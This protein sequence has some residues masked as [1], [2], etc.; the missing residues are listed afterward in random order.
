MLTSLFLAA[1]LWP[2]QVNS[3]CPPSE[4]TI[5]VGVAKDASNSFLYC[6]MLSQPE[7]HIIHIDYVRKGA[8]FA[9]KELIYSSPNS[10]APSVDQKDFRNGEIRKAQ[11]TPTLIDLE[12][13]P[14]E[15]K[16]TAKVTIAPKEADIIDAGFDNFIR[17]NWDELQAGKAIQTHF[18]S[19]LHQKVLSL[20][21]KAQPEAKCLDKN[22]VAEKDFCYVVE[23]DNAL[24]RLVLGNI[25]L[26][27]DPQRRL[28]KFNGVVNLVNDSEST[29]SASIFYYYK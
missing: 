1:T 17:A 10:F 14:N 24:L 5:I 13:K 22:E 28:K 12:Y 27:Y 15:R 7:E 23:I 11:V 4:N 6:E 3:L 21:I 9:T 25:K 2:S 20:R 16:K 19:I 18:G 26:V 29:Q 8:V